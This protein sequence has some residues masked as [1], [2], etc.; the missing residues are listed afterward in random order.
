MIP[1]SLTSILLKPLVYLLST[2]VPRRDDVWVFTSDASGRFAENPKYLFL[3][4]ARNRDDV[5]PVWMSPDEE[6]VARLERNGYEA[7]RPD[8]WRGR[9]VLLRANFV[10]LSHSLPFWQ[11]TGNATVLQLWHGNALKTLGRD[12]DG[13]PS[14]LT[15]LYQKI[16]GKD[17]DEFA[18]TN[19]GAPLLPFSSA[20]DIRASDAMVTGYPRNDALLRDIDGETIGPNA[21]T[22]ETVESLSEEATVIVYLPTYRRAFGNSDGQVPGEE[23]LNLEALN[24]LLEA[25]D[26]HFLVKL[27][28]NSAV[29]LDAERFDR[30]H[31]LPDALD[32]YP[33][34]K[35][36]DALVTDYSSIFFDYLLTDNPI[37]FYP[38]DRDEYRA[39]RGFYFGYD[40]IAPGPKAETPDE[41]HRAIRRCLDGR[42]EY[43]DHRAFVRNLFYEHQDGRAAERVYQYVEETYVAGENG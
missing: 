39:K 4:V 12:T 42:D 2:L 31:V 27:H 30:V 14:L 36:V 26:A 23:L 41:L 6:T 24:A 34:L 1:A 33:M 28:P 29:N 16:A 5:R 10:V 25:E 19:S 40:E 17:W 13:D 15:R 43:A 11:Y 37:L 22:Y 38:Y 3:H 8:S 20:H 9:Y 7:Y 18:I 21:A 35:H 32:V